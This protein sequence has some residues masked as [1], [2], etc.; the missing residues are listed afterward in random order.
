VISE[1]AEALVATIGSVSDTNTSFENLSVGTQNTANS[2]V[3][4]E[5]GT[6]GNPGDPNGGDPVYAIISVDK[7]TVAEGGTL[8]Y[9]VKLVDADGNAVTVPAG[10][11]VTVAL[12]WSGAAA[13]DTDT[14]GR[15][16]SVT[17]DGGTSEKQF[18][19]G[20]V[21]DVIS[22]GPEGLVAT[23]GSVT[24]TNTSFENLGV[25]TQ[26]TATS[27]VTD[28]PAGQGDP[29]YVKISIDPAHD[30]VTEGGTLTYKIE[31]VDQAGNPVELPAGKSVTVDLNWT[32]G[33]ADADDVTGSLPT[34]VTFTGSSS[35]TFD[36]HTKD[37]TKVE[38][39]ETLV[40][41]ITGVTDNNHVFENLQVSSVVADQS[42]TG[43]INDN[44][45]GPT[46]NSDTASIFESGT[47]GKS[48]VVLI[49]DRSGSMGPAGT[50]GGSDPDGAGPYT[51][52]LEMLKEAVSNLFES[53]AVHSVF[54]V[55]FSDSATFH[56]SGQ[57]G[58]WYTDLD[59][60][61][62][63]INGLSAGG[64]TDYDDALDKVADTF[65]PPPSGGGQLVSIFM[66]DGQPLNG[67]ANE[68][69]WIKFL[70]DN[71]FDNSYAVGFGGLSD[72]DKG[73]LEP[74]AWTP[75]ETTGTHSGAS[76]DHVI[77]VQ[78]DVDALTDA[79]VTS[80][81][82]SVETG[83][84]TGN[85]TGG[86][87]GWAADGWKLD[88]VTYG[89][90]T[91]HFSSA[92]DSHT[93]DLGNVGKVTVKGDGSYTFV[94]KD[95]FDTADDISVTLDYTA[96]DA[97]GSTADSTLTLTVKDR[98]DPTATDD[99]ATAYLTSKEVSSG[100]TPTVLADFGWM[101]SGSWAFNNV[102]NLDDIASN[103]M[104]GNAE[105]WLSSSLNWSTLDASTTYSGALKLT[106]NNGKSGGDAE[107][108]TPVYKTGAAA[109]EVLEFKVTD[110]GNIGS[111]GDYARWS[112]YSSTDGTSWTRVGSTHAITEESS[113]PIKTVALEAN[114]QYRILF[115]V[116]EG[117]SNNKKASI[118]LDDF[119]V[120]APASSEIVWEA[121]PL[122]DSVM[123]NDHPGAN[124][125]TSVVW[126][127]D[128]GTWKAA[129]ATNGTTLHGDYGDLVIK[130]DG[131]YIY[132]P[133]MEQGNIGETDHFE[134]KLV[135]ADGDQ[136][137]VT[138]LNIA[139]GAT[140]PGAPATTMATFSMLPVPD[141]SN[142]GQTGA[143]HV[144]HDTAG[145]TTLVGT[146]S[147]DVF[148]WHLSDQNAEP[149]VDHVTHFGV[150]T[151]PGGS[152]DPHGKDTLD[153]SDLLQGE[154][155]HVTVKPDGT[156][157]GDLTQYLHVSADQEGNTV[158]NVSA[159]GNLDAA[160]NGYDQQIVIDNVD[161]T[162]GHAGDT[163]AQLIN[164]LINDGKL[165]VDQG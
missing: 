142:D 141:A 132:T 77:V 43:R 85:D 129:D 37:D 151:L 103:P 107:L 26:N 19:V 16:D 6:P 164:S 27:Q 75:G 84:V 83:N 93:F 40:A 86:T 67:A 118:T 14:T 58:G 162:D 36:V 95:S 68:S 122:H 100:G 90:D 51:S 30:A 140:G 153:L 108:Y 66:S 131:S 157:T 76:D 159:H 17:I 3:T 49:L 50:Y 117:S 64:G 72:S 71:D 25:G 112:L 136:S 137:D 146:E 127:N 46:A 81:G 20:T 62:A 128:G 92:T 165:K 123:T 115:E 155:A 74:I 124:G 147:N 63:A 102:K 22:E 130:S 18:T 32:G 113:T 154:Q 70:N 152:A 120:T 116:N 145:N 96:R 4:D 98:S 34:S 88:S 149:A 73:Y 109:G 38:S 42:A 78:T 106:D 7:G 41:K 8:T 39:Q 31:L 133:N 35:T 23:I 111:S 12:N 2:Q 158:I 135:Q 54:I 79:L 55:S 24:D 80:A 138:D 148:A 163:Q 114:T 21:D 53:G 11:S 87:A 91:Y 143:E 104:G 59:S 60:A 69:D 161:L 99:N 10:K 82:G 48:D 156:V 9:T 150:G 47:Q 97:N 1:G 57:N 13:N 44:D 65:V 28:E 139:I 29:V 110:V 134:Y 126:V 125:E 56:N 52:R 94:G 15:P 121:T 61:M 89:S 5:P 33:T 160:G 144:V 119:K 45:L 101:D 105:S